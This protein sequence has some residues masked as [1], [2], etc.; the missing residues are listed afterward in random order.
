MAILALQ[1]FVWYLLLREHS[2]LLLFLYCSDKLECRSFL[3][4]WERLL[5]YSITLLL[6]SRGLLL[7]IV[8]CYPRHLE[9]WHVLLP[10]RSQYN[11]GVVGCGPCV[12]VCF[13]VS[14]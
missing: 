2:C 5:L 12:R 13:R 7:R 1:I 14:P 8:F 9:R 3:L 6:L 10:R 11:M 4:L